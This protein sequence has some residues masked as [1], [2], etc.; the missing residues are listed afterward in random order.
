MLAVLAALVAVGCARDVA[1]YRPVVLETR[2]HDPE[3]FTQGLVW[4]DGRFFE[5]SGRYGRSD[6]REVD[7]LTGEAV[8][9][10]PLAADEFAEGLALVEDRL[11]QLTYREGVAHVYDRDTFE[12]I[13]RF[14]YDG[15]GWGL[16]YDG[17]DLW[18]SDGSATLTRRDPATFEIRG[19]LAVTRD[20]RPVTRLNELAC[21]GDE[22]YANVWMT[23]DIVRIPTRHGRVDAVIDASALVPDDPRVRA[24]PDAVL[25]GVAYDPDE[26]RFF[27]TGKLWDVLYVVRFERAP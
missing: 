27:L 20:G 18:M 11:V 21:V 17:A 6:L 3:A 26:D 15:E 10:R 5:S 1:T 25:N 22:I 7:S 23:T 8:R 4:H 2:P 14:R 16:C 19:R 24:D 13:G 9:S 12:P